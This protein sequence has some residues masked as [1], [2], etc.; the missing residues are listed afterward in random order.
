MKSLRVVL[1][2]GLV[3]CAGCTKKT[4]E[5][6]VPGRPI[7][8]PE[9]T[10][11]ELQAAP[12][13]SVAA[14]TPEG[15]AGA[16]T[17]EVTVVFDAPMVALGTPPDSCDFPLL[18]EPAVAG[19]CRWL[20]DRTVV[21]APDSG[22]VPAT[23]YSVRIPRGVRALDG[24]MLKAD[25]RFEFETERPQL[26]RSLPYQQSDFVS[27]NQP[28]YLAFNLPME[29]KRA[30]RSI[31]LRGP[32]GLDAAVRVRSLRKGE[33][34]EDWWYDDK[35]PGR[36]LVVEPRHRL[37]IESEYRLILAEGLRAAAGDLGTVSADTIVFRTFNRM[38]LEGIADAA[39]QQPEDAVVLVFSNPVPIANVVR[40]IEFRPPVSIPPEYAS[41]TW[42]S[43]EVA[44][45]LPLVPET[46]YEVRLSRWLADKFG[47]RL[48]RGQRLKLRTVSYRPHFSMPTGPGIVESEGKPYIPVTMVNID[49]LK[50]RTRAL[51]PAEVVPYWRAVYD[52][53]YYDDDDSS[54]K[55]FERPGFY[56]SERVWRPRLER[57]RRAVLP[58][59]VG[60]G[61]VGGK[62]IVV[63]ELDAM[64]EPERGSRYRR[65]L[66]Q[67]TPYGITAKFA[68]ERGLGLVTRLEDAA[69]VPDLPVQLRDDANRVVW[70]GRTRDDGTV[71]LPGWDVV[72]A[73][74]RSEWDNPRLWLFAG[75]EPAAAFVHSDWGTGI[76]P[77]EFGISYDW[78]PDPAEPRGFIFTDKGLYKGGD[79][80]RLKGI[81]RHKKLG[82]WVVPGE[83]DGR[84]N[85]HDPRD[86]KLVSASLR[87][88]ASGSFDFRVR[89]PEDAPTGYYSVR[90]ELADHTF[91]AS[92]RV[93]SYR[94]ATFEVKV[95]SGKERYY[96][97]DELSA[98]VQGEYLFGAPMAGDRVSWYVD[99]NRVVFVPPGFGDYSFGAG[100][101]DR[102][103]GPSRVGAGSGKLDAQGRLPVRVRLKRERPVGTFLATLEAEVTAVNERT[104]AG[105]GSWL[106]HSSE[107][108]VGVKTA[109]SF[110]AAGETMKFDVVVVSPEG[111]HLAGTVVNATV[112]RR[113][114]KT[115]RKAGTGGRWSWVNDYRDVKVKT[116]KVRSAAEPVR[117]EFRPEKPGS[118][119]LRL[120]AQD[121]KRRPARAETQFWVSGPGEAA[122]MQRD[123]DMVELRR[124]R[125]SYAPG[126]TARIMV[127]SP[128]AGVRALVTVERENV[129]DH[130]ITRLDG[131]A[132]AIAVPIKPEYLPNVFVSVVLVK[133]RTA[134]NEFSE[135][136]DDL[137]KPGIKVGYVELPVLPDLKRLRIS[138]AP[139]RAEYRPGGRVKLELAVKDAAGQGRRAEVT[140][141]V[142]DLGVLKLTGFAT[143]DPFGVFYSR[144]PLSVATAESR[145]HV[146]GQRNY[147]EKGEAQAGDG[148]AAG[149]PKRDG[150]EFAYRQNFLETALW[151]PAVMTDETGRA[152]VEFDLPDNLTQWQV[153]AV[154]STVDRFGSADTQFRTNQPLLLSPSLPRFCR[155]EDEFDGG[156]IV[157]NRTEREQSVTV[158]AVAGKG[159]ELTGEARKTVA[160]PPNR[161]VEVLFH[162]RCTG[163]DRAGFEFNAEAG[164]ERDGLKLE[165]PV[166]APVPTEAY[167]IYENTDSAGAQHWVEVPADALTGVGGLEVTL[168]SSGLAGLERGL[169]WLR[170]YP[171][172]CLEQR[173]SKIL[174]FVKGEAV[175]NDFAL[176]ELRGKALRDFVNAELA[177]VPRYQQHSGGFGFWADP[178]EQA[179]P[180]L[181]AYCVAVLAEARQAGFAV[182]RR[183]LDRAIGYLGGWLA[184][185]DGLDQWPY[186]TDDRLTTRALAVYGLALTGARPLSDLTVLAERREQMSVYGRALLLKTAVLVGDEKLKVGI[187]RELDNLVKVAPTT[188]HYEEAVEGGWLFH[189]NV[190]TTALVLQALL[191]A[192][193]RYELADNVVRWLVNER[194][195]ARWRTTQENAAVFDALTTFY[196][197][198]ESVRPDLRATVRL[199]GRAILEA[200][201]VG[202]TLATQ[203]RVVPIDALKR[204][205]RQSVAVERTGAG[206][207]YYGL[208]LSYCRR[209]DPAA[210]D[211]GF[212]VEKT[213]RPFTGRMTGFKRGELYTVTLRITAGQD[214]LF[215]VVDDPLPAGFEI[216][217]T[218][219][220]T[221]SRQSAEKLAAARREDTGGW[222][223]DFDLEQLRA[224][225]YLLFATYLRRGSYTRTYLVR[226]QTAGRFLMPATRCEEMYTP[227]VWGRTGQQWVD[228]K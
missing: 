137:G 57:N 4:T 186:S 8:M 110:V 102:F 173:L 49:S 213:I 129:I 118:Y 201:L 178:K 135:Q 80:V 145:L 132:G 5:S 103:D 33:K 81:V 214:R 29:P 96:V 190:R 75:D 160:V 83:R 212:G 70:T 171:Y 20:G 50:V 111:K 168:A 140:V 72:G 185:R 100:E 127:Q 215:V 123:D 157:H 3:V 52:Y 17:T 198:Y 128:W 89:L 117:V 12:A 134:Q 112:L 197:R 149:A 202:R 158:R 19:R 98:T 164:A 116:F 25:Y 106:V 156:V 9:F 31:R 184:G 161:A 167:A 154:A 87:L 10:E 125:E 15:E 119:V 56:S 60:R 152:R 53:S 191:E 95:E 97:G 45:S 187:A 13:L 165:L 101:P 84:L 36:V 67:V 141:A 54:P 126:D 71:A 177:Q 21:F 65:A 220:E 26:Q 73:L 22:F 170:T 121:R 68:P 41:Y 113:E 18:L 105:R 131:T 77:Y 159:L 142:V 55:P 1:L 138:V 146:I 76:E 64:S 166:R 69:P 40:N 216:V 23:R 46:E 38:R 7:A 209:A 93:E 204:G 92:F 59:D 176:S 192:R 11:S 222:W 211:N 32:G 225:R 151:L 227:E 107:A 206:R 6:A 79:T 210:V 2:A 104:G 16:G 155:P 199:E 150:Y 207:L 180:W 43:T 217:N 175:I 147:G 35:E 88:S 39:R 44:L 226:T 27:L 148:E 223:G 130:F 62:G 120:E 219:F 91:Y 47:N 124:D 203:R 208:R 14:A 139:D 58:L 108:N 24:A 200:T 218:S 194:K 99:L 144:R 133:G 115:V 63:C 188:A 189:S 182:D 195:S 169:E 228:V 153:M 181:T 94:P 183:M 66:L 78:N 205:V 221:E 196:R 109:H 136:G 51:R 37:A 114:W 122:W 85:I 163:G 48:G 28:I 179:S 74:R 162:Y 86:E 42:A 30:A 34:P 61:L 172:D 224:D 174:P 143:P 90:Y 82:N 193:G